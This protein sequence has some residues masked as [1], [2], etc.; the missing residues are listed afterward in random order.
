M[1]TTL[2]IINQ[3]RISH[4][5][6]SEKLEYKGFCYYATRLYSKRKNNK[7]I[8]E[9]FSKRAEIDIIDD[10]S[11]MVFNYKMLLLANSVLKQPRKNIGIYDTEGRLAFLLPYISEKCGSISVFTENT[12]AYSRLQNE[13]LNIYGTPVIICNK[14]SPVFNGDIIFAAKVPPHLKADNVFSPNSTQNK[15]VLPP[16]SIPDYCNPFCV[17]AGLFFYGRFKEL[18]KLTFKEGIK[19]PLPL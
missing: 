4:K 5:F 12:A 1:F 17:T 8:I 2:D 18:G 13:I 19:A 10:K 15:T 16:F 11:P 9:K 14:L 6:I 3:S 7:K